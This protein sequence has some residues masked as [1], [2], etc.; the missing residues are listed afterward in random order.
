MWYT[1]ILRVSRLIVVALALLWLLLQAPILQLPYSQEWDSTQLALGAEV[2]DIHRHQPHPPGYPLWVKTSGFLAPLFGNFLTPQ[3]WLSLAF[4]LAALASFWLLVK[5]LTC[6]R[7][8]VWIVA[9]LAFTPLVAL[10]AASP[11][12]CAVDLFASAFT[13]LAIYRVLQGDARCFVAA[14]VVLALCAG[15]RQSGAVF[16]VPL[17][18]LGAT[19]LWRKHRGTLALGVALGAL[20]SALW[21]LPTAIHTGGIAELL[22]L[23]RHQMRTSAAGTSVFYGASLAQHFGML[24]AFVVFG[25]F[26]FGIPVALWSLWFVFSHLTKRETEG[27]KGSEVESRGAFPLAGLPP[28]LGIAFWCAWLIPN[29]AFLL[30]VHCAKPGYLLLSLP[31]LVLLFT[32]KLPKR[33]LAFGVACCLLLSYFPYF[34][35]ASQLFPESTA[36]R[37][38]FYLE[39]CTPQIPL[40]VAAWNTGLIEALQP[41]RGQQ[42]TGYSYTMAGEA[43]NART[44]NYDCP[45]VHWKEAHEDSAS[46]TSPALLVT[47]SHSPVPSQEAKLR[48]ARRLWSD[49]WV[50]LWLRPGSS[51]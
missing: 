45:F 28:Y 38:A 44:L 2:F 18:L 6:P 48:G 25:A 42:L 13:A 49:G 33:M 5:S 1:S 23:S 9:L 4:T 43:P 50:S 22:E 15:F 20:A 30:L 19:M 21:F 7:R 34:A 17:P 31:P 8:A 14:C 46:E 40:H 39:R 32:C 35:L 37:Y 36:R 3:R 47:L 41:F 10:H 51:E 16:L 29:L 26:G 11:L 12:T 24:Y 27:G